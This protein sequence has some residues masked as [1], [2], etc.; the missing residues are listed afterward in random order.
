[1][2]TGGEAY[3]DVNN[4]TGETG[5]VRMIN[6]RIQLAEREKLFWLNSRKGDEGKSYSF[7]CR[8]KWFTDLGACTQ[9]IDGRDPSIRV[10]AHN[11]FLPSAKIYLVEGFDRY[12]DEGTF[13]L[14]MVWMVGD[15]INGVLTV[16]SLAYVLQRDSPLPPGSDVIDLLESLGMESLLLNILPVQNADALDTW[17]FCTQTYPEANRRFIVGKL[18]IERIRWLRRLGD[19]CSKDYVD[20]LRRFLDLFPRFCYEVQELFRPSLHEFWRGLG[21]VLIRLYINSHE[22]SSL[23]GPESTLSDVMHAFEQALSYHQSIGNVYM[24]DVN[25]VTIAQVCFKQ[26]SFRLL[27]EV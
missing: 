23:R 4:P 24:Q 11:D 17:L 8:I 26:L 15:Y 9:S 12:L 19:D 5:A 10:W 20:A 14:L 3:P 7:G 2:T 21:L 25:N 13:K 27:D 18:Q 6:W 16:D 1:M 22:S